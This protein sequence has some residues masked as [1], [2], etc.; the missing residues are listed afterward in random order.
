MT[1][2]EEKRDEAPAVA[3]PMTIAPAAAERP[4]YT[5]EQLDEL[6]EMTNPDLGGEPARVTR[7]ALVE[8]WAE[9]GFVEKPKGA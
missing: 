5:A 4:V 2:D 7:R 6:I 8:V 3:P 9:K 1:R